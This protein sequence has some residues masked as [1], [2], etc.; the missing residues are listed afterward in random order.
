MVSFDICFYLILVDNLGCHYH[1][2]CPHSGCPENRDYDSAQ[3]ESYD[4]FKKE[5]ILRE[6]CAKNNGQLIVQWECQFNDKNFRNVRTYQ[7]PRIMRPFED[8]SPSHITDLV[9]SDQL[10]GFVE[11]DISS[12]EWLI[13]KYIALNFPPVIRR[14]WVTLDMMGPYMPERLAAL[15]R[16]IP[17]TGIETVVNAWHGEK[18]LIFTPL[19]KHYIEM[20]LEITQVYDIM[21]YQPSKCFKDF[22]QNCVQVGFHNKLG[23]LIFSVRC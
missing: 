15:G 20:G 17:A 2:P 3:H 16:K 22:I 8:R 14:E 9:T 1:K 23:N 4:W 19:L 12:P 10:F 11:C 5:S 21:Q 18:M 7:F 6:W 13:E